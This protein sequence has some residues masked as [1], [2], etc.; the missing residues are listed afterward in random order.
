MLDGKDDG[1]RNCYE[2]AKPRVL[3]YVYT[4][5]GSQFCWIRQC[6]AFGDPLFER[7]PCLAGGLKGQWISSFSCRY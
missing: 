1:S 3:L 4:N 6:R 2:E 5:E 7:Q